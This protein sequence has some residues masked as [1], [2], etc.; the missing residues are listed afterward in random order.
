MPPDFGCL[1]IS[2]YRFSL[3]RNRICFV[4]SVSSGSGIEIG[5]ADLGSEGGGQVGGG[6]RRLASLLTRVASV[7]IFICYTEE[8]DL[9]VAENSQVNSVSRMKES[10]VSWIRCRT[11]RDLCF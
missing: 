5:G 7:N 9:P 2:L 1:A 11:R 6:G 4:W 8:S 3:R 10:H